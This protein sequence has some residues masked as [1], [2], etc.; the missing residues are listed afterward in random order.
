MSVEMGHTMPMQ[1]GLYRMLCTYK[2]FDRIK[3]YAHLIFNALTFTT[4]LVFSNC[5]TESLEILL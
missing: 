2:E 5:E 1:G 3:I 4:S